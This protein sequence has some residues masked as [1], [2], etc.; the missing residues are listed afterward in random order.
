VEISGE[1]NISERTI[2]SVNKRFVEG[3]IAFALPKKRKEFDPKAI[4]FDG[5]FEAKLIAL[6]RSDP[7]TGGA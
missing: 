6:A 2:E 1:L 4:K 7:P 3:W 5:A